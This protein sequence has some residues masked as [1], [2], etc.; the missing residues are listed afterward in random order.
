MATLPEYI[1]SMTKHIDKCREFLKTKPTSD[2]MDKFS[3]DLFK[4]DN[5][6]IEESPLVK[7]IEE[8]I[9]DYNQ[10]YKT[11][12]DDITKFKNLDKDSR[13]V[14]ALWMELGV[15]KCEAQAYSDSGPK[16]TEETL[17]VNRKLVQAFKEIIQQI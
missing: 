14:M 2:Q 4:A 9:R 7:I 12:D 10:E 15:V 5:F 16:D 11:F 6:I 1:D 17:D 8:H 13:V 3:S